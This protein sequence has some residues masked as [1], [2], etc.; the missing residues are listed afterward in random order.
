MSVKWSCEHTYSKLCYAR[1][2]VNF[3]VGPWPYIKK[4]IKP[5]HQNAQNV[6]AAKLVS[7]SDRELP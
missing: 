6:K 3:M 2:N 5:I 4:R 7:T 1:A